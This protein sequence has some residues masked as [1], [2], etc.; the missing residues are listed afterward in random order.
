MCVGNPIHLGTGNKFRAELDYQSGGS[1]P[2]TFT[3]YYNSHLPDEELGGWRHTY[4]RSVEVNASKYGENMVVL[5]RPEGQQLAF[6]NSS[7]VWVPTWK[8]DDT[9]TKDA[10]GW[11]YTQSDGVVEAY[12]ETGRLTGIEKPNGNHITLSYLNGEL[13]SITDGFGRTIQF[14][15]QDGRMVSVTDPAGGSIQYQYNSAGKLAEV[16]Y[17]DNT[18]R[19]Y[20]YDD[21][22]APGLLSGLVDENGNRFATWGYDTQGR[23]VLS[24]HAG[25]AEKTQVSYNADGS[26]SVTNALGH[27]QRYTYSRHNG[28]L[29]PDVVEGAPCTGFVGGKETYVYDSK[30]L[31]S[32][33]TDRAGQKRTFTHNDRGL[34]TTQI[35]QT[36]VRLRPTGFLPSRSR[37]KSQNQPD[38]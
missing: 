4:S 27:V 9:L 16:I 14:Q 29:K 13:S 6:Y 8:T 19:S 22:N 24:E 34:E 36:G 17:Q 33:I 30:G 37:Q 3:R 21:P 11:R 2:F 28:M 10:T 18:S 25:G 35:D 7:S 15:Y 5:H 32:S 12:D 26:V 31:V 38:H 1:D 23:A 20:L